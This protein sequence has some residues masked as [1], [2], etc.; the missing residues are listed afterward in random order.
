MAVIT[1]PE[2]LRYVNEIVR[3]LCEQLRAFKAQCDAAKITWQAGL[4]NDFP[5]G[6]TVQDRVAEGVSVL[7]GLQVAQAMGELFA[8][9][10]NAQIISLPCVRQSL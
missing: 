2:A 7:T 5:S 3:P 6:D 10:P 8:V 9:A 1:N 4:Q